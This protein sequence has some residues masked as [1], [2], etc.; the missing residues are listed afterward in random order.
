MNVGHIPQ[1]IRMNSLTF[2]WNSLYKKI[3]CFFQQSKLAIIIDEVINFH[4][5]LFQPSH[6]IT[7][8]Y[9]TL[10]TWYGSFNTIYYIDYICTSSK[11][12][13]TNCNNVANHENNRTM[14]WN[15]GLLIIYEGHSESYR[16]NRRK[17]VIAL[18]VNIV[19]ASLQCIWSIY[20]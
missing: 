16:S 1:K 6:G 14:W 8:Y 9:V 20:V 17:A 10:A 2:V 3:S 5:E 4:M 19:N 11:H 15:N 7:L 13:W 18:F 12:N